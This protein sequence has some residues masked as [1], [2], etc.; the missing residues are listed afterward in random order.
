[1]KTDVV[2][3]GAGPAGLAMSRTLAGLAVD[4]V[5]LERG[6]VAHAWRTQRW[7]SL[8]LLSPNWLCR[9]PGWPYSGADPEGYMTSAELVRHLQDY[10]ASFSAPIALG[11]EVVA[12]RPT[13]AGFRVVTSQ[14]EWQARAVVVATGASRDPVIPAFAKALSPVIQQLDALTYRAPGQ[15]SDGPALVVGASASGAQIAEELAR[16]GR[17]VTVAVGDHVR[18]PRSY[19]GRDIHWWLDRAGVLDERIEDVADPVR[20]R[21]LPSLQL[22]GSLNRRDLD[23]N[24]LQDAG[25]EVV[26]RI[27]GFSNGSLQCSGSLANLAKSADLKMH[28]MLDRFD[29]HPAAER[30]AHTPPDRPDPIRLATPATTIAASRYATI[31]WATG[32]RPRYDWLHPSMLDNGAIVH[33]RG[34]CPTPGL[35]VLGLPFLRRRKSGFLDGFGPDSA[36]IAAH[37]LRFL[38]DTTATAA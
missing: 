33:D 12:L 38:D 21:S 13:P 22:V 11:A 30:L 32:Y 3:V 27:A 17:E 15:L 7:D 16:S 25:V 34:V 35:Y 37:L 24:T 29:R 31:V 1:M 14:G 6:E 4:H 26:G 18:L 20:A 5:V 2:V 28:R 9:L 36:E 23:L 10:E 19:R 8:R